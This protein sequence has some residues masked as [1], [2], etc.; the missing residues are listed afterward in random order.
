M[1][2]ESEYIFRVQ[3]ANH[4]ELYEVYCRSVSPSDMYGFICLE[5][6]VFGEASALVIDPSE[7]RLKNEFKNVKVS[8]VPMHAIFRIDEV[9]RKAVQPKIRGSQ[10]GGTKV[11]SFPGSVYTPLP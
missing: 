9:E 8:F 7:E 11:H 5:E 1:A 10:K 6:F 2:A 3:F 4:E